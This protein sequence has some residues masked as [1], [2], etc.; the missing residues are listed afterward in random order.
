MKK[1]RE[2]NMELFRIL[3]MFLV[4]VVHADFFALG[5]PTR[6][7]FDENPT[8]FF[9]QYFFES[10]SIGCVNM[11]VLLS[12]WFGIRPS[13]KGFLNL[14]F[15]GLFFSLGI[16]FFII[17]F[18]E[19]DFSLINLLKKLGDCF[20]LFGQNW[21]I[22]SYIG[23]Y[24]LSP[25]LNNFV[26]NTNKRT[27]E[28]FLF[29]FFVFQT[30]Y[31][32]AFTGARFFDN[33]YS[34]FSFIGLYVLAR[35]CNLYTPIFAGF[36]WN[37]DSF[38][39]ISIVVIIT[40]VSSFSFI[41]F[42]VA[43]ISNKM[44]MYTNP[45]VIMASLYL[46]LCF[47]KLKISYNPLINVVAASTFAV[48]LLHIDPNIFIPYF[49]PFIKDLAMRFDGFIFLLVVFGGLLLIYIVSIVLDQ[50]RIFL[51]NKLLPHIIKE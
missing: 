22:L 19:T 37:I 5:A 15:Q 32:W 25:M 23:L 43:I 49:R 20:W 48:Y 45:L 30:L 40:F 33:G 44:F 39:F 10:L 13:K 8:L 14:L 11:F 46:L 16:C 29:A 28:Y 50:I 47:S 41:I 21:F 12:G 38:I 3:A 7:L 35:Y 9:G 1:K 42:D 17:C 51:W 26:V 2:S 4:L 24:I 6:E 36:S 18:V 31:G 27:L 34:T